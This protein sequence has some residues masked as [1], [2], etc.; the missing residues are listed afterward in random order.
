MFKTIKK[1]QV[2]DKNAKTMNVSFQKDFTKFSKNS[3][4]ISKH[5]EKERGKQEKEKEERKD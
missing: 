3:L 4:H 5:R 2:S 1:P